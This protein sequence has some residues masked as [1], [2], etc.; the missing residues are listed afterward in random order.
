MRADFDVEELFV[1]LVTLLYGGP[2][3]DKLKR[4]QPSGRKIKHFDSPE[5]R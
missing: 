2:A 4:R 5:G 1:E 3:A